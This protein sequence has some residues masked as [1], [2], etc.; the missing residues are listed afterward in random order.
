ML[1]RSS[2]EE[3]L[4]DY[5]EIRL[6]VYKKRKAWLLA[7]FDNEIQWLSEKARFIRGV[8]DG[9]LKVLN[10]PLAVIQGQLRAGKFVEEIWSKL[11]DIKTWQYTK[12]EVDKLIDLIAKRTS[13]RAA[14]KATSVVQMWKNNLRDL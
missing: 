4:V 6:G 13:D 12:E 5:L 7:E 10:Q 2:P 11:L 1:F 14:L 3:I 9:S 8:I